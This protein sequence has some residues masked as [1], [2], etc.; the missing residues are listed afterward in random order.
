MVLLSK[1][2]RLSIFSHG[3]LNNRFLLSSIVFVVGAGFEPSCPCPGTH[4]N[5][6]L[7]A[8][9]LHTGASL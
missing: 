1:T 5:A 3:L 2:R 4:A 6:S 9:P 7:L 8:L